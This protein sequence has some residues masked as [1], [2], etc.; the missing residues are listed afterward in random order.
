[1][2]KY[3]SITFKDVFK[4]KLQLKPKIETKP[5]IE[6]KIEYKDETCNWYV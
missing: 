1:M 4:D 5:I 3:F 6:P 2:Q